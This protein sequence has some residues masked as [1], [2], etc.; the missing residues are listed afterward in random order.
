MTFDVLYDIRT[1]KDD[2]DFL[3]CKLL[4]SSPLFLHLVTLKFHGLV[5]RPSSINL[6]LV[7]SVWNKA[8]LDSSFRG[9]VP[10][11]FFSSYYIFKIM[12]YFWNTLKLI[13]SCKNNTEFLCTG[14]LLPIM[15]CNLS[16]LSNPE[17]DIAALLLT[18][19]QILFRS[20]NFYMLAFSFL[21]LVF[22]I[23]FMLPSP[24]SGYRI[25]ISKEL[26]ATC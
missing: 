2:S 18:Q 17:I 22:H 23:R 9:H 4:S 19:V 20:H 15:L 7:P 25:Y 6:V 21:Y 26:L 14:K 3:N 12:S 8:F 16:M 1:K 10:L 11:F 24:Q 13:R 5:T